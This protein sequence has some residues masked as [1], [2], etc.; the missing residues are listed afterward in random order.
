V[1]ELNVE[2]GV[3]RQ[4]THFLASEI[5]AP[6]RIWPVGEKI[7]LVAGDYARVPNRDDFL[8]ED[9]KRMYAYVSV[10]KRNGTVVVEPLVGPV[11]PY[12][13][14]SEDIWLMVKD[15]SPNG[16]R[17]LYQSGYDCIK[18]KK[19]AE[20]TAAGICAFK[21]LNSLQVASYSPKGS[22]VA[23]IWGGNPLLYRLAV[24]NTENDEVFFIDLTW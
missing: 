20:P 2:T 16:E 21:R 14:P 17:V 6:P 12:F 13:W 10:F 23:A 9:G 4:L 18:E 15:I 3:E 1:W 24:S 11:K 7:M 8:S 22:Q 19:I 5:H